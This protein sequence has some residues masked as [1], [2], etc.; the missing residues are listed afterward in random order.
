[1]AIR[2]EGGGGG[3]LP[4]PG[5]LAAALSEAI[6]AQGQQAAASNYPGPVYMGQR[7]PIRLEGRGYVEPK[8]G[9][10]RW[11]T[12]EEA[13][14]EYNSWSLK[15][16]RDFIAQAKLA[17]LIPVDGG[18]VEGAR[19]WRELVK[20]A[21]YFGVAK[22]QRVS[23]LDILAGYVKASG[24]E[25]AWRQQGVW[26]VNAVTK[27]RRYVGPGTYLG[28]GLAQQTDT[29]I[30]LTDPDTAR[31][32]STQLFQNLMGRDPGAGE[33]AAFASALHTA[34][35]NSPVVS[36]TTTQYDMDTG[37]QLSSSSTQTGGLTSDAK[38]Y[39]GEQQI[40]GKKEYGVNQA[41]TTYQNAFENL[42]YGSPE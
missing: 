1:M 36:T 34:E 10:D 30:D 31:A 2:A 12:G 8:G 6:A 13:E 39:I 27:E 29:R 41:V 16:R 38:A 9:R 20:E 23:P 15:Q 22:K 4:L 14:V 25:A 17:G 7:A 35:Q 33:L 37:Q 21:S 42:I 26:E 3:A 18:E 24:S 5:D 11:V 40:K 32:I 28:N 19:I